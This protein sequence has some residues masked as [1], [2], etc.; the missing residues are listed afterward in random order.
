MTRT[1]YK[2]TQPRTRI[3]EYER[4]IWADSPEQAVAVADAGTAWPES[5][6]ERTT[7][8]EAGEWSAAPVTDE[9]TIA[10]WRD[11]NR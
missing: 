9:Q 3:V 4:L 2:V 10:V 8:F 1:L 7:R 11:D 5:Y 6:D